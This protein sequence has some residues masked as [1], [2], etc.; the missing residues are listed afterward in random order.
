MDES[1]TK[2]SPPLFPDA[3][4]LAKVIAPL[5][6]KRDIVR[7]VEEL[8]EVEPI[9]VDP[10]TGIDQISVEDRRNEIEG[11]RTKLN[12]FMAALDQ[13]LITKGEKISVDQSEESVLNY[14]RDVT[15]NQGKRIEEIIQRKE[16]IATRI[17]DLKN[18]ISLLSR[19]QELNIDSTMLSETIHTKTFLGTVFN[20]QI[21]RILWML[22]EITDGKYYFLEK[23]ASQK[24]DSVILISILQK[25]AE[26]VIDKLKGMSVQEIVVP[27]DVDLD[28]LSISDCMAEI[29][30][31]E[32]EH[33][34]LANETGKIATTKGYIFMAALEVCEIELQRIS[35]ELKMRRTESTCVMWAWIPE[36]LKDKF[37][38]VLN[39]STDGAAS[40][41]YR[42]G[43]FDPENVPSYVKNSKFMQPM[44]GIVSSFGTPG[45]HEADPYPFVKFIMP[46]MFGIMFADVGHGF[47][48]LLFG[49][50]AKRK[51]DKMDKIPEGLSGYIFGGPEL[52]IIMGATAM[53]LGFPF[54]SLFGDETILWEIGFL[55]AL[56]EKTTWALLFNV[57]H[58][59]I[60]R[61]YFSFLILSFSIGAIVIIIGLAINVYQLNKHRHSNAELQAAMTLFIGYFLIVIGV[62]IFIPSYMYEDVTLS[63]FASIMVAIFLGLGFVILIATMVIEFMAH[64]VD[65]LMLAVDHILSLMSNTF[66]F[67]RLLAMNTVH[68]VL[69]FLP[70]LFFDVFGHVHVLNHHVNLGDGH[71]WADAI[72]GEGL[73]VPWLIAALIGT[74][75]VVPIE[76]VFS[77]L[78]ALRLNWVEFF[79]KFF[80]GTGIEFKPIKAHRIYTV[81]SST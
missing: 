76:G 33:K 59:L 39:K 4:Q 15:S 23:K 36:H 3:M 27:K 21:Q 31:L 64:K 13:K 75:I 12:S 56:F 57:E 79:G 60:E 24:E 17:S 5:K 1:S 26:V 29:S 51:K 35:V 58:G 41:D 19:F 44:R 16:A 25:D 62:A 32:K 54:N 70:Y 50:W 49:L 40:L 37:T 6:Y 22:D 38:T 45:I 30:Q 11:L 43:D 66:S 68:F 14:I 63:S 61:D 81:E 20:T 77:T 42:K 67:G 9:L 69:A 53:L 71:G 2:K 10:R 65:G 46:I 55:R 48:F 52:I 78:Q 18:I 34:D 47:I 72:I 7:A 28:G 80:K 8:G 73:I 74:I